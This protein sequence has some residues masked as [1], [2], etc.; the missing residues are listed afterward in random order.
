MVMAA[1]SGMKAALESSSLG[2]RVVL[3]EKTDALGGWNAKAHKQLPTKAPFTDLEAPIAG[4]LA[5]QVKA[6]GN[7]KVYMNAEVSKTYGAP[8][9][10]DVTITAGG[11]EAEEKVGTIVM[12]VGYTPY[13][14]ANS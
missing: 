9:K 1:A 4:T 6:D 13:D 8:G 2:Y 11:K 14:P 3:V 10:Y 7:I 12:A 5:D